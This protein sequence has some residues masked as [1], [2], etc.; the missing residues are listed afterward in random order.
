MKDLFFFL[1]TNGKVKY[2][3]IGFRNGRSTVDPALCLEHEVRRAQVNKESV[4]PIPLL[5]GI[6]EVSITSP[7]FSIKNTQTCS[8][9]CDISHQKCS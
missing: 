9:L 4:F 7:F 1:E 5:W 2:Y 8:C 3:Q 6:G